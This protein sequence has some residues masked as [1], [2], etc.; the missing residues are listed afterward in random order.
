MNIF[1]SCSFEFWKYDSYEQEWGSSLSSAE[2]QRWESR[3]WELRF[4]DGHVPRAKIWAAQWSTRLTHRKTFAEL[5]RLRFARKGQGVILGWWDFLRI[6]PP[7]HS[8]K[9]SC[10]GHSCQHEAFGTPVMTTSA[11]MWPRATKFI[12]IKDPDTSIN[13]DTT[14]ISGMKTGIYHW[15]WL[16]IFVAIGSNPGVLGHYGVLIGDGMNLAKVST[17]TRGSS[18]EANSFRVK[19]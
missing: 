7:K 6:C 15:Q 11:S 13:F 16:W 5:P 14:T 3:S 8:T 10:H 12:K 1:D 9:D 17:C 19:I 4:G 2:W 18:L